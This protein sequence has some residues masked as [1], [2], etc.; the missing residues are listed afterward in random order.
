MTSFR[1]SFFLASVIL[2]ACGPSAP[3]PTGPTPPPS[4]TAPPCSQEIAR[5]CPDGQIDA[6][7]LTP[8]A[9]DTHVC[10]PAPGPGEEAKPPP[11]NDP[12]SSEVPMPPPNTPPVAQSKLPFSR[13]IDCKARIRQICPD[14]FVDGCGLGVTTV[15]S[16]VAR[17]S[18]SGPSCATGVLAAC[19]D[20]QASSCAFP[21]PLS[22]KHVCVRPDEWK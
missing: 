1:P 20:G 8:P 18:T 15:H 21:T 4:D 19:P 16:C 22:D 6:C 2:A 11:S 3:P 17:G 13:N 7:L 10:V 5:T 9:A 14:G 12:Q